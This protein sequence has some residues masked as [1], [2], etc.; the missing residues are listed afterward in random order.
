MAASRLLSLVVVVLSVAWTS[1]VSVGDEKLN[2][3]LLNAA[4]EGKTKEV[5]KL[6]K[7]GANAGAKTDFGETVLHLAGICMP[8]CPKTAE[9]VSMLVA[10]GA[11]VNARATAKAGLR[12]APLHWYSTTRPATDACD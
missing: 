11:D 7:K 10:H 9:M 8:S 4:G 1:S 5:R 12:M 6:L 2:E 3:A